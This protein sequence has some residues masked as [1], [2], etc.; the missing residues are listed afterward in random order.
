M[1]GSFIRNV[2]T[3]AVQQAVG[4]QGQAPSVVTE[5]GETTEDVTKK[6]PW[7]SV[8]SPADVFQQQRQPFLDT[9]AVQWVDDGEGGGYWGV[10][11]DGGY[12]PIGAGSD[13]FDASTNEYAPMFGEGAQKELYPSA[14]I[15]GYGVIR[16]GDLR[17]GVE[18]APGIRQYAVF[19]PMNGWVV[20]QFVWDAVQRPWALSQ[21]GGG[22]EQL[23]RSGPLIAASMLG[24]AA[25]AGAGAPAGAA[26]LSAAD[27]AALTAMGTE[28]GLSGA[29]LDAFVASGGT[30]GSTAAGGGMF[31]GIMGGAT[32]G[33]AQGGISSLLSG[34]NPI[35]G[36]LRGGFTGGVTSGAEQLVAAGIDEAIGTAAPAANVRG[37]ILPTTER[38]P[39]LAS[40]ESLEQFA[41]RVPNPISG[42]QLPI[43]GGLMDITAP[44]ALDAASLTGNLVGSQPS[45]DAPAPAAP[46]PTGSQAPAKPLT[47]K[48]YVDAAKKLNSLYERLTGADVPEFTV[49]ERPEGMTDE[50]YQEEV[51]RYAVEYLSLDPEAMQEAGL[52]PGTQEYLAYILQQADAIIGAVFGENAGDILEGATTEELQA[53]FRDKTDEEGEALLR[54]LYVRGAL[55]QVTQSDV[56]E[57]PFTGTAEE[58]GE[59]GSPVRGAEAGRQRGYARFLQDVLGLS[60]PEAAEAMKGL[61]GRDVDLFGLER[62]ADARKLAEM[63]EQQTPEGKRRR[64][65][66]GADGDF[67]QQ[68]LEGM[69]PKQ[70]QQLMATLGDYSDQGSAIEE[71]LGMGRV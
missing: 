29:A 31:S 13:T 35:E 18:L 59:I 54:A 24:G 21:T 32:R 25:L 2:I 66:L 19:D 26:T 16:I 30:L 5:F 49:P 71:L 43:G 44:G 60:G 53:A 64:G 34:G 47:G 28:A 1:F 3:Q 8:G 58:L 14:S 50:E 52:E 4:S 48:D 27:T 42:T 9:G 61:L 22:F 68:Q 70:L 62:N 45:A 67:F 23:F 7:G 6:T 37:D 40:A 63:L 41:S 38:L 56:V 20:P 57:D 12:L 33:A 17:E 10:P 69:D 65:M 11:H 15:D 51:H 55:G 39:G 36:A 46:A